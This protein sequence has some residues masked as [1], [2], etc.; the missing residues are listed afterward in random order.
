MDKFLDKATT[1]LVEKLTP[2]IVEQLSALIPV[3]AAAAAKAIAEQLNLPTL[4]DLPDLTEDVRKKVSDMLPD[5]IN[6]PIL[7]DILGGFLGGNK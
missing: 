7:G 6:I 1:M 2:V 4:P 5:G 3:A